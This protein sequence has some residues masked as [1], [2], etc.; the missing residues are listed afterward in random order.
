[1]YSLDVELTALKKLQNRTKSS[2]LIG[3]FRET[4]K[5]KYYHRLEFP[6]C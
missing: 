3:F 4:V 6:A 2:Q 1:L 5:A